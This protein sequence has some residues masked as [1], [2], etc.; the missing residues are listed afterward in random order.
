M[1]THVDVSGLDIVC[2]RFRVRLS[3]INA[4]NNKADGFHSSLTSHLLVC[5]VNIC[6]DFSILVYRPEELSWT[7]KILAFIL[8]FIIFSAVELQRLWTPVWS[9]TRYGDKLFSAYRSCCMPSK[10]AETG[11]VISWCDW[12]HRMRGDSVAKLTGEGMTNHSSDSSCDSCAPVR[13]KKRIII[14]S[15]FLHSS[16][17]NQCFSMTLHKVTLFNQLLMSLL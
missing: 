1:S 4:E 14:H 2:F 5:L 16:V 6:T 11:C 10:P 9:F 13:R 17:W 12:S 8:T 3:S 15:S 7:C